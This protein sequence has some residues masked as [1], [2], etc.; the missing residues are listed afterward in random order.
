MGASIAERRTAARGGRPRRAVLYRSAG[1]TP[2]FRLWDPE[3]VMG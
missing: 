1:W 2:A 3:L